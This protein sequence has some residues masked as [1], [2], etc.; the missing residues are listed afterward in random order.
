MTLAQRLIWV[1][2]LWLFALGVVAQS[3]LHD[4]SRLK[5]C[6]LL[7][8]VSMDDNA[9]TKVTEGMGQQK[10]DHVAIFLHH[11]GKPYVL[12]AIDKGVV[13]TPL[14]SVLHRSGY[15]LVGRVRGSLDKE[16]TLHRAEA[17]LGRDYDH[18]F[19]AGNPAIYCSE[20]V[21]LSYTFVDGSK[22]FPTI[23]MTFT[24]DDGTLLPYWQDF[25]A[26]RGLEVPEGQP[27]T[28]PGELSRRR[29]V[30]ILYRL[31]GDE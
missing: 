21:E 12:E 9:I 25:Y 24:T 27:G 11:E 17:Y 4:R 22:V 3:E 5:D 14:D 8:H 2:G 19:L 16:R 18:L 23:P 6:D 7:F 13:Y 15:H 30:K 1:C 28:N 20:L 26:E 29:E 31:K 10:I